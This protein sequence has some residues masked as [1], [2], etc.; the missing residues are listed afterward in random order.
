MFANP[1]PSKAKFLIMDTESPTLRS[2]VEGWSYED[3]SLIDPSKPIGL[4]LGWSPRQ[5]R[6]QFTCVAFALVAGWK[7]MGPPTSYEF[8][9][10]NGLKTCWTWW[11]QLDKSSK[12]GDL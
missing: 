10:D 1:D 2:E 12:S 4:S 6:P 7:L 11:L 8:Q 5:P 9:T 3:I